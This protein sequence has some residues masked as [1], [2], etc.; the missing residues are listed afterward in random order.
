L[1]FLGSVTLGL[2]SKLRLHSFQHN[3]LQAKSGQNKEILLGS[4]ALDVAGWKLQY[5]EL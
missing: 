2:S 3:I 1:C 5:V 4:S